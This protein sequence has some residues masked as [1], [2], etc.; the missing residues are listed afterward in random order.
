MAKYDSGWQPPISG[1]NFSVWGDVIKPAA[2]YAW[3][4][5]NSPVG[6]GVVSA[7]GQQQT[8][9]ANAKMAKDQMDFQERMAARQEGFQERMSNT[10]VQRHVADLRAAGLNPALAFSSAGA[11]TP[12]GSMAGGAMANMEDALSKGVSSGL[13]AKRQQEE[14]GLLR[15]QS[16]KTRAEA[17]L[18]NKQW[19]LLQETMGDQIKRATEEANSAWQANRTSRALEEM[20]AAQRANLEEERKLLRAQVPQAEATARIFDTRFGRSVLPWMNAALPFARLAK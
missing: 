2:G 14:V 3:D 1:N 5:V 4:V 9:A 7:Y 11:S 12:A 10:A 16:V 17:Q 20:Y 15:D 18:V 6:A 19:F 8:N 13:A